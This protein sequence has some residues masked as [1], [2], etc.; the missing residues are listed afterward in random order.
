MAKFKHIMILLLVLA[1]GCNDD[2]LERYPYG[3]LYPETFYQT[4]QD[5][6]Y[7][8]NACYDYLRYLNGFWA[9]GYRIFGTYLSDDLSNGSLFT[10]Y[11]LGDI[12]AADNDLVTG[13]W[14]NA[15]I[16]IA[17]CNLS[18]EGIEGMS[19]E[20]ID[21]VVKNQHLGEIRFIRSFFYFRLVRLFGDVPLILQPPD[22]SDEASLYPSRTSVDQIYQQAILPD[23]EFAADNLP[24]Y[25]PSS[26]DANRIT[27]GAANS[28]LCLAHLASGN[29]ALA[30]QFGKL[31]T[32]SGEYRLLEDFNEIINENHEFNKESVFEISY[33]KIHE[34]FNSKYFGTTEGHICRG[35]VYLSHSMSSVDLRNAFSLIDGNPI[36]TDPLG[37][38]DE[39]EFWENR[40]PRFDF[41]Y[42]T[43]LDTVEDINGNTVGFDMDWVYDKTTGADFQKNTLWYGENDDHVGLN[44]VEMRYAEVLLNVAEALIMQDKFA[45]AASYINQVR[46]RARDYAL[47]DPGRYNQAGLADD[48]VLPE[49]TIS[50]RAGGLDRLRYEKRVEFAAE[51]KRGFD[52]RRWGIEEQTWAAVAGFTWDDKLH[53]LPI[54][55]DALDLNKK[56]TP[57]PGWE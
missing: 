14:K 49:I 31:V 38:Y 48:R 46:K 8:T 11:V 47:A 42:Y 45:E 12:T 9:Q 29:W 35:G 25:Y 51:D 19:D 2:F 21:P 23:L 53:L 50:D 6:R 5:A 41:T 17:R 57:N 13:S 33:S 26:D 20:L 52:L 55:Q 39:A 7:A 34:N 22:A 15:Y 30:E 37:I 1:A 28:Y 44:W 24:P 3:Q 56:L 40:D 18:I 43:P 36:T 54:P 10:N 4:E 32:N 16:A 27:S